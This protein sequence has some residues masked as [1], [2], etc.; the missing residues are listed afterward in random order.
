VTV[1]DDCYN[2]N[3][4][5]VRA[6]LEDLAATAEREHHSRRVAVLGDMLELGPT[7]DE[8]HAQIG[9][10]A[11]AE[12]VDLLVT[13]GPRARSMAERF[14]GEVRSAAD[15]AEA[16][17]F[18]PGLLAPGDLVL[19]KGSRAVGLELVCRALGARSDAAPVA[20]GNGAHG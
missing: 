14:A 10:V 11:E 4:M 9:A 2:A 8:L 19:V 16:A 12:G 13:V 1:I 15:A 20:A 17:E 6:A 18:V 5:S 3:P 7:E